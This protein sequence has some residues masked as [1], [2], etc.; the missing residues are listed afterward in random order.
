MAITVELSL[1]LRATMAPSPRTNAIW[2]H[3]TLK[4]GWTAYIAK[5]EA[6]ELNY[7][8]RRHEDSHLPLLRGRGGWQVAHDD[9]S[10]KVFF[11]F[12]SNCLP[13]QV[14]M[15]LPVVGKETCWEGDPIL[16]LDK[17]HPEL[18]TKVDMVEELDD[19]NVKFR[20]IIQ[21]STWVFFLTSLVKPMMIRERNGQNQ[22]QIVF[23]ILSE[24]R[25]KLHISNSRWGN[26]KQR[27]RSPP[28]PGKPT[29]EG[30]G[31]FKNIEYCMC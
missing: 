5:V 8:L 4:E 22:P 17:V 1:S 26:C 7:N 24:V 18:A 21:L 23:H 20:T 10:S 15:V 9:A 19:L 14:R 6:I 16:H 31:E 12:Q 25:N 30:G 2:K 28:G 27:Q 29:L 13:N 11:L 3:F